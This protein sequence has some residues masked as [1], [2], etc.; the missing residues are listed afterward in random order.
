[1]SDE[2]IVGTWQGLVYEMHLCRRYL[3]V[4]RR[5]GICEEADRDLAVLMNEWCYRRALRGKR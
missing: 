5:C 2:R 3:G 4:S 1:M